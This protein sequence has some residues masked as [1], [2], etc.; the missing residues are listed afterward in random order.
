MPS[1]L[2]DLRSK[3]RDSTDTVAE[4]FNKALRECPPVS[5]ALLM[6]LEKMFARKQINPTNPSMQQ[7]LVYQAGIDKVVMHLRSQND[8][9]ERE[10]RETRIK[11][12]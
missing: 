6:Y 1:L 2:Q 4:A 10:V 11:R 9:Q 8:R 5:A 12:S 7:E 3:N